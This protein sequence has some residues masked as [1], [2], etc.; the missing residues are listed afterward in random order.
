MW[1]GVH[2]DETKARSRMQI[3]ASDLQRWETA[4]RRLFDVTPTV[5]HEITDLRVDASK[6][7]LIRAASA[8]RYKGRV[9]LPQ[10][11][12][13]VGAAALVE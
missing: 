13:L 7:R 6:S 1:P 2:P 11:W 5:L 10:L 9:R 3:N 8:A 12:E 4:G